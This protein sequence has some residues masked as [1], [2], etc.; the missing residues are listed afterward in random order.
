MKLLSQGQQAL[1]ACLRNVA[2]YLS[3]RYKMVSVEEMCM[4]YILFG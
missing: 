3:G 1:G 4:Q 2:S